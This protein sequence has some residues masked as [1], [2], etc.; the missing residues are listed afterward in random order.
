MPER[1]EPGHGMPEEVP[2]KVAD[3]SFEGEEE[4]TPGDILEQA[5]L[6]SSVI[7][8][9]LDDLHLELKQLKETN[10]ESAGRIERGVQRAEKAL[11]FLRKCH[12]SMTE[13]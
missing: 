1:K 9:F 8:G 3:T 11:A 5:D 6:S 2:K 10:P 13:K 12:D 7:K 4:P